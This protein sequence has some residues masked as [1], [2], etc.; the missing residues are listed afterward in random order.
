VACLAKG[1]RPV[2]C[3]AQSRATDASGLAGSDFQPFE[4]SVV[5]SAPG[6]DPRSE[7]QKYIDA[8]PIGPPRRDPDRPANDVHRGSR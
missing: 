8:T 5:S 3:A 2:T 1:V 4:V 7:C 6:L